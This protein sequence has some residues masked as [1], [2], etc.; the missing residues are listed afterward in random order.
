MMIILCGNAVCF[1]RFTSEACKESTSTCLIVMCIYSLKCFCIIA[2]ITNKNNVSWGNLISV[3]FSLELSNLSMTVTFASNNTII[4]LFRTFFS[5]L[6]CYLKVYK[7]VFWDWNLIVQHVCKTTIC[8]IYHYFSCIFF[9]NI[10]LKD[11][12][13]RKPDKLFDDY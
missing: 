4:I 12:L 10:P 13:W 3:C 11:F 1:F 6:V 5:V 7:T 2:W 8:I 9:L